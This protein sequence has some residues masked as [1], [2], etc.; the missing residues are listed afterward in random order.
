MSNFTFQQVFTVCRI[1]HFFL[2]LAIQ[3]CYLFEGDEAYSNKRVQA[4]G[5]DDISAVCL[6]LPRAGEP[7]PGRSGPGTYS[8]HS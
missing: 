6:R 7:Y 4:A 3:R 5:D 2:H 8:T 1:R